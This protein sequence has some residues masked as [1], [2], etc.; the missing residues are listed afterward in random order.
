MH[1]GLSNNQERYKAWNE[2]IVY[3]TNMDTTRDN[4]DIQNFE[5]WSSLAC[6]RAL[7]MVIKVE[8]LELAAANEINSR[9]KCI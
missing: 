5:V 1:F 9:E 8:V 7:H 3:E 2:E 4:I 6:Q